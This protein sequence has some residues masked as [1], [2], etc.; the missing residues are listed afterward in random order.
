V[1]KVLRD[2]LARPHWWQDYGDV[3]EALR[4]E[5][6]RLKIPYAPADFDTGL[7]L[8]DAALLARRRPAA[9]EGRRRH[10]A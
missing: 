1:A 2:L 5:L 6:R 3:K 8:V 9:D 4:D 7:S 10:H